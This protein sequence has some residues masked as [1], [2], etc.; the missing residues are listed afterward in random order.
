MQSES[1]KKNFIQ[2]NILFN[3]KQTCVTQ[4]RQIFCLQTL[5][6]IPNVNVK[7]LKCTFRQVKHN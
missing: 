7:R 1:E 6:C 3:K 2:I 4:F 5:H